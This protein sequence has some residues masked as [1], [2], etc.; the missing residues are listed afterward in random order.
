MYWGSCS[1]SSLITAGDGERELKYFYLKTFLSFIFPAYSCWTRSNGDICMNVGTLRY[2]AIG[3]IFGMCTQT[4]CLIL[5]NKCKRTNT[6]NRQTR[7]K[8]SSRF[9]RQRAFNCQQIQPDRLETY[10]PLGILR[11]RP[12]LLRTIKAF[13][14]LHMA[15]ISKHLHT[16][17]ITFV[18]ELQLHFV[19]VWWTS[20]VGCVHC[21]E[22]HWWSCSNSERMLCLLWCWNEWN[23]KKLSQDADGNCLISLKRA[24]DVMTE[25]TNKCNKQTNK[26]TDNATNKLN[27]TQTFVNPSPDAIFFTNAQL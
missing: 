27:A 14:F 1:S 22:L 26:Q 2:M 8:K 16:Y 6:G 10:Y 7:Q 24:S 9:P 19:F 4:S 13:K 20:L 17:I 23:L 3:P 11:Q 12:T 18:L 25:L 21:P 15:F 5:W